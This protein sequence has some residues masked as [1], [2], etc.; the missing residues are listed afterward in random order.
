MNFYEDLLKLDSARPKLCPEDVTY[1]EENGM[2]II[3]DKDGVW[4]MWASIETMKRL[5]ESPSEP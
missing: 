4:L 5:R 3:K 2:G 1:V